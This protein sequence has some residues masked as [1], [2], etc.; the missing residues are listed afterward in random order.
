MDV[1]LDHI[2]RSA[3]MQEITGARLKTYVESFLKSQPTKLE[4]CS[5]TV[6]PRYTIH[7][8]L[9]AVFQR[10]AIEDF[11][12]GKGPDHTARHV[13]GY[14][15]RQY[16][17]N[18]AW[19][20]AID[21]LLR[22]TLDMRFEVTVQ[23]EDGP[24]VFLTTSHRLPTWVDELRVE[25]E[26]Q[27]A[28]KIA[29]AWTTAKSVVIGPGETLEGEFSGVLRDYSGC[30]TL[31]EVK[32]LIKQPG[33]GKAL[34]LGIY[35]FD[36]K[37]ELGGS[38]PL[39]CLG[40]YRTGAPMMY[41]GTLIV[42][43]QNSGKTELIVRWTLAAN[44]AGYN[45]FLV[46]V[47]GSLYERLKKE[48]LQG[49]VF[50]FTTDPDPA[51]EYHRMNLLQ[52][53][54]TATAQ[55]RREIE[56][57]AE[58]LLPDQGVEGEDR[59]RRQ[60][61]VNWLAA[62]INIIKLR[63]FFYVSNPDYLADLGMVYDMAT[64]EDFLFQVVEDI[65]AGMKRAAARK[66]ETPR[67]D[68]EYWL[69]ELSILLTP[70]DRFPTGQREP[71]Y[72][73]QSLT[74]FLAL[75]LRPFSPIGTL[76]ERTRRRGD[77]ALKALDSS[78]QTTIILAAREQDMEDSRTV[79]SAAI[80]RLEQI[81]FDRR[82]VPN[83]A[84]HILLL[85]DE[86]RRIRAFRAGEYITFARDAKAGCV[87]VY[88]SITQIKS[89]AEIVEILE[90]VGTQIYLRSMVGETAKRFIGML[91]KRYRPTYSHSKSKG[92]EGE[93]DSLQTGQQEV[94]YLTTSEL[95]RM[96]AGEYPAI[97]YI[98][99]HGVGKP[100]LVD[101]SGPRVKEAWDRLHDAAPPQQ[102]AAK[103]Q[104]GAL[105]RPALKP[106]MAAKPEPAPPP[107]PGAKPRPAAMPQPAAKPEPAPRPEPAPPPQ[108]VAKPERRETEKKTVRF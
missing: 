33:D 47:K 1:L 51:V 59:E 85:L 102:T 58:A 91:P 84:R 62:M 56:Q 31:D 16:D 79:V 3:E 12:C 57:L 107:Q 45:T 64:R 70:S 11:R 61:R 42:A 23:V 78:E 100:F 48:G 50:H 93:S 21:G 103:P 104:P 44:R 26:R 6:D 41:N 80:K 9:D 60:L 73:Y 5:F 95:Y 86:T 30:A 46:D 90:N 55:G 17:R 106:Q 69:N 25:V 88:Q 89:D 81:L 96:P 2:R 27:L 14:L 4:T 32:D 99:D 87:I 74:V 105:P 67:P 13:E 35:C 54:R 63:E 94:D 29:S 8:A 77:F 22:R 52:G 83:P 49:R 53:L 72:T 82:K 71:R 7:E 68:V 108:P 43:P 76:Y 92:V 65:R 15:E 19:L 98:K 66:I 20:A 24:R 40:N 38:N 18:S 36:A 28:R 10:L 101:M 97:V 37:P 34:P 75:A 39:L